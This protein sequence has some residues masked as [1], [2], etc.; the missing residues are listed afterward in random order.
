M[1][2]LANTG[3]P[4]WP[5]LLPPDRNAGPEAPPAPEPESDPDDDLFSGWEPRRRVNRLTVVLAACV[6]AV[7]G[8]AVGA[9]VAKRSAPAAATSAAARFGGAGGAGGAGAR[10]G[11]GGFTGG[12]GTGASGAQAAPARVLPLGAARL[13]AAGVLPPA[14]RRSSSAPSRRSERTRSR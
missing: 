8:F 2:H 5:E 4:G 12:E 7:A 13:R 3:E 10:G 11:F 9:V 6:L 14:G 1:S